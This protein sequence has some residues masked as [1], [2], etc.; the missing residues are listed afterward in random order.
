MTDCLV[1]ILFVPLYNTESTAYGEMSGFVYD[2]WHDNPQY[3]CTLNNCLYLGSGNVSQIGGGLRT[4]APERYSILNNCYHLNIC[5]DT[6]QGT[7]VTGKQLK[8]G[9]VTK[10]L[11]N[12]R[13]DACHWVQT[14]GE[15]PGL[16]HAPDKSKT[17]YVYYDTA[18]SRW[19]CENF[20]LTDGTPL[21][22]A[23]DFTATKA[24]YELPR[25]GSFKA[26]TISAGNN[27]AISFKDVKDKLE[28][29]RPY[30][31]TADGTPQL[32]GYNLQVKAYKTDAL[33]QTAGAFS[34]VGTVDGVDNATAAAANAYI[35]QPD[36]KFHKVTTDN[37][38][39]TVPA[40]RAYITC[41][42]T[43]GA[44]EFSVILEGETTGIDGVT[45]DAIGTDGPVYDL[46][47]RCVVD[48]LAAARHQLPAGVYIV[49][50][51]KVIVK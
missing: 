8:S 6:P 32:G 16:Y 14:L 7:R 41:P 50:R 30:Y 37:P 19:A 29:Y 15:M 5:S 24:T 43:L 3:L 44:K 46:Q 42:K 47:G 17:N 35:L 38:G 18:N 36:G 20:R 23:L 51:R 27:S 39:A 13:T 33:K 49:S 48:R 11:Q 1:K 10:L 22:I 25:N 2:I 4:F 45:N 28:A 34:F 26:H 21:P 9:E 12:N 31:I 40:Y